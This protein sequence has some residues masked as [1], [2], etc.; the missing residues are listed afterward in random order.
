MAPHAREKGLNPRITRRNPPAVCPGSR[1]AASPEPPELRPR[2]RG[3][4]SGDG[5][6]RIWEGLLELRI[7]LQKCVGA[8]HRLP[9]PGHHA[10]VAGAAERLAA[11]FSETALVP[12]L[13]SG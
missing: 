3:G 2:P 13:H 11:G 7:L 9:G 10:L 6:K 4:G 12:P 5:A 1:G 8:S